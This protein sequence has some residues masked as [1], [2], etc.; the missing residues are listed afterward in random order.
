[1]AKKAKKTKKKGGKG[2]MGMPVIALFGLVTAFVFMPSTIMLC[3]AML[4]TVAAGLS[5][6]LRG[7]TR[8]L[9]IGSMN[10]AGCTPF[11]L[12]LWS[13]GHNLDNA[14]SIITD[15][16]TIIVI[17]SAAG[18]GWIIDWAMSGIVATLMQQRGS[19]RLKDITA[20]H[21]A[22]VERWG[23]EVTGDLVLDA[24]GFPVEEADIAAPP[25]KP[26]GAR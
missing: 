20:R 25:A 1:M 8:A 18:L 19:S 5:D 21:A 23:P 9:T 24:Y 12:Q 17:Y 10:V 16:R 6:R 3:L 26:Q 2:K 7:E 11:L 13:T 22:L 4:P 15:P 14:F